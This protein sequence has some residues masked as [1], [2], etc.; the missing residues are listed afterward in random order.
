MPTMDPGA[1]P[2]ITLTF[3]RSPS[4]YFGEALRLARAIPGYS[5]SAADGRER[6]MVPITIEA[7]P[8]AERLLRLVAG[9]RGSVVEADG[10]A[11]Y[12][13]E[14][15]RLLAMLACF[16]RHERSRLGETYCWG[17]PDRPRGRVPCRLVEATLP[18][19]PPDDYSD[20]ELLPGLIRALAADTFA[21]LCPAYDAA[22][23]QLAAAVWAGG[24]A[25]PRPTFERLLGDIEFDDLG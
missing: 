19:S 22:S 7:M 5:C 2:E 1:C 24:D 23:V 20:P 13:Y 15:L 6:H 4:L 3:E 14:T 9:W 17:L 11:L 8:V 10:V 21:A 18:W 12:G 25:G 16:R